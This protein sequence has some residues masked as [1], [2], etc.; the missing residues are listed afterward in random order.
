MY[1]ISINNGL[2][3]CTPEEAIAH[4][5]WDVIVLMMDDDIRERLH[6]TLS[7]PCSNLDF[8]VA[9]LEFDDLIIG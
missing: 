5:D 3:T 7:D 8:L 1:T 9:Y 6:N 2:S 4:V